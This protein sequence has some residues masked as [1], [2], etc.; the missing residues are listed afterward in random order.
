MITVNNGEKQMMKERY[1]TL[2]LVQSYC[3]VVGV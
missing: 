1:N 2:H 3:I